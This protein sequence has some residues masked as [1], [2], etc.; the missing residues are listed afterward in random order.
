[1]GRERAVVEVLGSQV[2]GATK[3]RVLIDRLLSKHYLLHIDLLG[4]ELRAEVEDSREERSYDAAAPEDRTGKGE[5]WDWRRGAAKAGLG[6]ILVGGDWARAG[7]VAVRDEDRRIAAARALAPAL[8]T[9]KEVTEDGC[10]WVARGAKGR[11]RDE[12]GMARASASAS[13]SVSAMRRG[14]MRMWGANC[15]QWVGLS[16]YCLQHP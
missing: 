10:G 11:R 5:G 9:E 12:E 3:A 8:E 15:M 16:C 2:P 6:S 1:V 13:A 4:R 14:K 7:E